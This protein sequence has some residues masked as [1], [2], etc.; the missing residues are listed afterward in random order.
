MESL[1]IN[2]ISIII[3]FYII[4]SPLCYNERAIVHFPLSNHVKIAAKRID[5]NGNLVD[6]GNYYALLILM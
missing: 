5:K 3:P 2:I 4:K 1:P 6:N